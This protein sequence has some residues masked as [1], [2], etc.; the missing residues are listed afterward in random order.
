MKWAIKIFWAFS[1]YY[2]FAIFHHTYR[3]VSS[4]CKS[5]IYGRSCIF[6][7]VIKQGFGLFVSWYESP[8][9]HKSQTYHGI[10]LYCVLILSRRKFVRLIY[11]ITYSAA[12]P[13]LKKYAKLSR[14]SDFVLIWEEWLVTSGGVYW[15]KRSLASTNRSRQAPYPTT[16]R[17]L[18][19][20]KA[21]FSCFNK[22]FNTLSIRDCASVCGVEGIQ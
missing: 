20:T 6:D 8:R 15:L 22:D 7:K 17:M 21:F 13:L 16:T 19:V 3:C 10:M 18:G 1:V 14:S 12:A 9:E 5:M 4:Q 11:M 2:W